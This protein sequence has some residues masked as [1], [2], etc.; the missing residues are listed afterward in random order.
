MGERPQ[1]GFSAASTHHSMLENVLGSTSSAKESLVYSYGRSFNGFAAK[2][3]D[4]EVRRVSG[5][6]PESES[7]NDKGMSA[8]PA[9]WNGTCQARSLEPGNTTARTGTTLLTSSRLETLMDMEPILLQLQLIGRCVDIISVSLGSEWP[10]PYFDDTIA[11]R[12][13]HAM[14]YGILTSNSGPDPYSVCNFAPW[15]LTV[16]ASTIDR[17]FLTQV[18]QGNGQVFTPDLTAP[19]ADTLAA[20][21]PLAPPSIYLEDSRRVKF[22]IISGTSMSCPHA[23]GAAAYV[24]AAHPDWSTAAIK[25]GLM[26]TCDEMFSPVF[27]K[28]PDLE[29]AYESGH[30]NPLEAT[31]PG[32]VYDASE[33]DYINFLCKQGYN[34]TFLRL[35]TGDNSS[36][37]NSTEP[38]RARDLNYPTFALAV[39]DG[40]PIKGAFTRTVTNVSSPNSTYTVSMY[41][42]NSVMVIV[43]PSILSFSAIGEKK[44]FTMT[45]YGPKIAQ[46]PIMSGAIMWKDGIHVVRSPVV[47]YNILPGSAYSSFSMPQKTLKFQGPSMHHKSGILGQ[48]NPWS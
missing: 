23:T 15:T 40:Q 31:D 2:L 6:W 16:A 4:D 14:R 12:S 5:I 46:L 30:I 27:R 42:P 33:E 17:K 26:T 28:H 35:I 34:T 7:F 21:C 47:V 25:S 44:T 43:E 45:V 19:G 48:I 29:F 9:K 24:K 38:E 13:Y 39:E 1:G 8:P 20:W 36:V 10:S 32:L 18:V 41:I 3:S 22:S 11:I 37:C